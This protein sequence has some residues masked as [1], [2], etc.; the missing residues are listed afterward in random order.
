MSM[1]PLASGSY[2]IFALKFSLLSRGALDN[3]GR[4]LSEEPRAAAG[5]SRAG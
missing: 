1:A 5:A 2:P 3:G 4:E